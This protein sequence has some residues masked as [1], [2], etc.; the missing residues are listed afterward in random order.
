MDKPIFLTE[1]I[2]D[3]IKRRGDAKMLAE[4]AKIDGFHG[5]FS[6]S[7]GLAAFIEQWE[8][9]SDTRVLRHACR[10]MRERKVT[11]IAPNEPAYF[12]EGSLS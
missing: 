6:I 5:A 9:G 12:D 2:E 11:R 7:L 4:T 1:Q 10:I 3:I 8:E